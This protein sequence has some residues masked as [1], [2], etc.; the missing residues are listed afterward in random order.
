MKDFSQIWQYIKP[1][2]Y[3][4]LSN[5][6][7]NISATIFALFSFSLFIPFLGILFGTQPMV[8]LY[9]PLV[10][11]SALQND[12]YYFLSQIIIIHGKSSA[13]LLVVV[14][15]VIASLFKNLFIFMASYT[16]AFI[17]NGVVKDRQIT[18]FNKI[19]QLP[20]SYY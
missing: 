8:T 12:L 5:I 4:A 19:I 17:V 16:M 13:L 9:K 10:S 14:C 3:K 2:K 18:L 11:V 7:L 20:L 1:Y 6:L 15:V